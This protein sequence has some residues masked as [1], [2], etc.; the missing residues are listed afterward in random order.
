MD[1]Y[2]A[3]SD[4]D[5]DSSALSFVDAEE[6]DQV[7]VLADADELVGYRCRCAGKRGSLVICASGLRFKTGTDGVLWSRE[8]RELGDMKK[9]KKGELEITWKGGEGGE[10]VRVSGLG[11]RRDQVFCSVLGYSG[12][13][14]QWTG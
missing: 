11:R 9:R 12:M 2:G 6:S 7:P 1:P 8:W 13:K 3:G 14:W 10:A 5:S 4:S